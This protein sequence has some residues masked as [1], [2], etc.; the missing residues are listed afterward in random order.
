MEPELLAYHYEQ[1]GLAGPAVEYWHRAARRGAERSANIEALHHFDRALELLKDLPQG[2]ERN[3]LELELLLAR[4]VPLLAVKGYASDDMGENYRRAKDLS[5]EHSGSLHQFRAIRG[6]WV[7]HL[8]RGQLANARGLAE[9][10]LALATREQSS[11]L[12][13]EAHRDLG[14]TY[15]YL[16][17]FDEAKTHLLAAKSMDDPNQHRSQALRY[18]QEPGITARTYLARTLWILGEVEHVDTLALEAIGMARKLEHPYTLVFNLV[19]L[20]WLYSAA[21]NMNRTLELADEAIAVSTQYSFALG[22]AWA[23]SSQGWA[24]AENGH[25][26][27]LGTL[28]HGLAAT[29]ATGARIH[30]TCTLALLAEIYLRTQRIDE[31][32]AAIEEAQKLAV[33]GGELFWQA[34]LLRLKGELLLGQSDRSVHPAEECLCKALKIAHDQHAK[35]LELRAATSLARLWRK[36]NK[37]DEAKRILHSVYSGFNESSDNLDLIE[38]KTVLE[39]LSV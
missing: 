3:D 6:L 33:T 7:F 19:F 35:M 31:G 10:L 30:D 12:L 27:G 22:L 25:E 1:A 24:M 38:A 5:Q 17:R 15:F 28:L 13:V 4:G 18:G 14:T 37:V 9:N 39:Q 16:G 36:H 11:D 8:V 29:R 26:D 20:S 32:L 34:E 2:P 21:R 23:T